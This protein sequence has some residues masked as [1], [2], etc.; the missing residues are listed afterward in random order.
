MCERRDP[1]GLYE[2]ARRG[3][4]RGMT[5][6]D[7]PYEAPE[8]PELTFDQAT[9]PAAAASEIEAWVRERLGVPA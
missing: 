7:D 3:E 5:G 2:R 6:I 8:H 4:V 1:K 9:R